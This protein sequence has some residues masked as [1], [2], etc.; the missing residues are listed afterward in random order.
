MR[1]KER[2]RNLIQESKD[3]FTAE[4]I[5][6]KLKQEYP[7]IVLATVYNNLNALC[8]EGEI[9]RVEI[10]GESDKF[11]RNTRH[12][13]LFCSVCGK[14]TDILFSDLTEQIESQIESSIEFYEL[15]VRYIC[16]ECK[17][18]VSSGFSAK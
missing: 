16:P 6:L 15:R 8:K 17:A 7:K 18:K 9:R 4:E 5:F 13:H 1:Y 14:V 12:D 2:I 10:A 11:D 3:H